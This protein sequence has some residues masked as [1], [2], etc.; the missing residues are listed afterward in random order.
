MNT[1]QAWH[2][3]ISDLRAL[4]PPRP[5]PVVQLPPPPRRRTRHAPKWLALTT[6]RNGL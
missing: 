6:R 4:M 3:E 1:H 2:N 5:K